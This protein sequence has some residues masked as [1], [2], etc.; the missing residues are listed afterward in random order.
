MYRFFVDESGKSDVRS[1]NG[2]MPHFIMA[3]VIVHNDSRQML[4]I[5]ADQIKFKYWG[6]TDIVFHANALRQ[7]S[8]EFLMFKHPSYKF[9][10]NEFY[11]D[12]ANLLK[13]NFK[14]GIVSINKTNYINSIP[15]LKNAL[16]QLVVAGK[17]SNWFTM[18]IGNEKNLIK[19][20]A[21]ELITMYIH[22]LNRKKARG[23]VVIE[24]ADEAQDMTIFSAYNKILIS[25]FPPFQMN[26]DAVRSK[27]TGIS[28]VTKK[29]HDIEEQL[30]DIAAHYF[31]VESRIQDGLMK[32]Y[33]N[34]HDEDIIKILKTKTF[35]YQADHKNISENSFRKLF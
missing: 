32:K 4:K 6:T 23:E 35:S 5:K 9:S 8:D 21:T 30:A 12:F 27:L 16:T 24:S 11:D 14:I 26:T 17:K 18:V 1:V 33:P 7:I 2:P 29:N 20:A 19:T 22:Y 3:G 13:M 10:I 25:G 28:F 34:S 31:N 15:P